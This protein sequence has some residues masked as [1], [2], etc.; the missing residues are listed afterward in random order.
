MIVKLK[1]PTRIVVS[2]PPSRNRL[3]VIDG[4]ASH[5]NLICCLMGPIMRSW[6]FDPLV[7][8]LPHDCLILFERIAQPYTEGLKAPPHVWC[9]SIKYL[10]KCTATAWLEE[11]GG[12]R[13]GP[14]NRALSHTVSSGRTEVSNSKTE[15]PQCP[16][17][18]DL[19]IPGGPLRIR[20]QPGWG[21]YPIQHCFLMSVFVPLKSRCYGSSDPSQ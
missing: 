18:F 4:L 13:S 6:I 3:F 1:A 17:V 9:C 21:P 12:V 5:S 11:R 8:G 15:G 20:K 16:P 10:G 19:R 7:S 14:H 2:W